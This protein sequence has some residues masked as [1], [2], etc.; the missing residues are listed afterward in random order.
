[1]N[2]LQVIEHKNERVLTTQ[3]LAEIYETSV[4]NIKNNFNRNKDRF[5]ED[6]DFYLLKGEDLKLFLQ[7]TNSDLQNKSKVRSMYLWTER[8][9]NRH[10]KILDTDKAWQQFDVLEETYFKVKKMKPMEIL[11][12]QNEALFELDERVE[13]LE[14][15]M[16]INTSQ[17]YHLE[18]MVKN[19]VVK[20]LGG[21]NSSAY[22]KCSKKVF[23]Q[24]WRDYKDYFKI[25]SYRDTLKAKYKE[26]ENYILNWQPEYNLMIEIC[27]YRD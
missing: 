12:L 8:G 4:N 23:S 2:N 5:I 20:M 21:K 18:K 27:S 14:N 7:V 9:A 16:T 1:M 10:S 25:P 11:K 22:L 19:K 6:R 15:N 26:A 13:H 24:L 3:Q 17:Q